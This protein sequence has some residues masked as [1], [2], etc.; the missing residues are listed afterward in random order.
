MSFFTNMMTSPKGKS[1][2]KYRAGADVHHL[3]AEGDE[4]FS[5][6]PSGGERGTRRSSVSVMTAGPGKHGRRRDGMNLSAS[7][8]PLIPVDVLRGMADAGSFQGS[9][10]R[11]LHDLLGALP[12]G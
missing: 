4:G 8:G 7:N 12:S 3:G 5:R 6:A 2:I 10:Q 1:S 11:D 9:L